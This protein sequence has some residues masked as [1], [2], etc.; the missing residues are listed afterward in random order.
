MASA[1][2][3]ASVKVGLD[4]SQFKSG[5]SNLKNSLG[6]IDNTFS[7][8]GKDLFGFIKGNVASLAGLA[9]LGGLGVMLKKGFDAK[10]V[11]EKNSLAIKAFGDSAGDLDPL[12]NTLRQITFRNSE[13]G[14]TA[15]EAARKLLSAG[16][17]GKEAAALIKSFGA[18]AKASPE[19]AKM[20]F[21]KLTDT[22]LELKNSGVAQSADFKK[23]QELG[24]PV[25]DLL[26]KRLT[27]VN[28][29]MINS[30][31][32]AEMLQRG[33]VSSKDA[34]IALG[35]ASS[36]PRIIALQSSMKATLPGAI[37]NLK[38]EINTF[39]ANLVSGFDQATGATSILAN[40]IN[41]I[42]EWIKALTPNVETTVAIIKENWEG[43][44]TVFA[45]TGSFIG[46]SF[47]EGLKQIKIFFNDFPN[48]ASNLGQ[49]FINGLSPITSWFSEFINLSSNL[50]QSF[51]NGLSPITS[52]FSESFNKVNELANQSTSYLGN[53]HKTA[54]GFLDEFGSTSETVWNSAGELIKTY[55][56]DLEGTT[57][58]WEGLYELGYSFWDMLKVGWIGIKSL[59]IEVINSWLEIS[60]KFT[61][62]WDNATNSIA[63]GL[64][65]AGNKIGLISEDTLKTLEEDNKSREQ[66]YKPDFGRVDQIDVANETAN[67]LERQ[68]MAREERKR[69]YQERYQRQQ[70]EIKNK[71]TDVGPNAL[72][73]VQTGKA[74]AGELA[75][76]MSP[77]LI[78]RG[79]AEEYKLM[80]ERQQQGLTADQLKEQQK[81]NGLLDDLN[82]KMDSLVSKTAIPANP[83]I[84]LI[85]Q[86]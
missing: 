50:G 36:D 69:G 42:A 48:I 30:A 82:N 44:G 49:S 85:A 1:I 15:G 23:L 19:E 8:L 17:S 84:G 83:I 24:L 16:Y 33:M 47:L 72:E 56:L 11:F 52:W 32:A 76:A 28:G 53:I 37:G 18:A 4:A 67:E 78:T 21:D 20:V 71:P 3:T 14:E 10:Q 25:Y 41:K 63:S 62:S 59:G 75:K 61:K 51:I 7:K 66:N 57:N 55:G 73:N 68:R 39:F 46:Q 43:L 45:E 22:M 5:V 65:W 2:T 54:K 31:E 38:G 40:G 9:G 27:D 74:I 79:G 13:M 6:G 80:V 26:A 34:I 58:I 64:A 81:T 29:R 77:A 12:L 86:V 70:D 35:S 60:E